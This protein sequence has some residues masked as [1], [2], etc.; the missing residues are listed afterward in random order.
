MMQ[1]YLSQDAITLGCSLV[2]RLPMRVD[3]D[4]QAPDQRA[5]MGYYDDSWFFVSLAIDHSRF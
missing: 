1:C 4:R 2:P 5:A 3:R